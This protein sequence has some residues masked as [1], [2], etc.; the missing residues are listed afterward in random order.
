MIQLPDRNDTAPVSVV[1]GRIGRGAEACTT[2]C[3]P[4]LGTEA[5]PRVRAVLYDSSEYP[6]EYHEWRKLSQA[7][8]Q[9]WTKEGVTVLRCSV[10]PEAFATWCKRRFVKPNRTAIQVFVEYVLLGRST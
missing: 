8:E 2:R 7:E 4:W 6:R 1:A 10:N 5:Y 9:D 3:I